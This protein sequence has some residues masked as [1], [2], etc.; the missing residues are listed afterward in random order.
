M[1]VVELQHQEEPLIKVFVV[2]LNQLLSLVRKAYQKV[3]II[4]RKQIFLRKPNLISRKS[5]LEQT[6]GMQKLKAK[7]KT[8]IS[9]KQ[10]QDLKNVQQLEITAIRECQAHLIDPVNLNFSKTFLKFTRVRTKHL[11]RDHSLKKLKSL[12][13][14]LLS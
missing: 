12:D 1:L 6:Y 7:A 4:L 13:Q 14:I 5:N 3:T 10:N 2:V 9:L 8:K 11:V